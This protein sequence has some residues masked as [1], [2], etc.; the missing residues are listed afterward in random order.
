M[1]NLNA[2]SGN[3]KL[4]LWVQYIVVAPF[5]VHSIYLFVVG[6]E[7]RDIGYLAILPFMLWRMLHNQIWI[8]YSRYRTAKGNNLIVDKSLEFEQVDRERNW[9][10]RILYYCNTIMI[11]HAWSI[12]SLYSLVSLSSVDNFCVRPPY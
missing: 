10:V 2:W 7:E 8:S 9:Y 6:A 3:N 1:L 11:I 12:N 5:V 4:K